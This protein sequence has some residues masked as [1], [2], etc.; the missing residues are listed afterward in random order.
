MI[1]V[2]AERHMCELFGKLAAGQTFI[3]AHVVYL[4]LTGTCWAVDLET[5]KQKAFEPTYEV[6]ILTCALTYEFREESNV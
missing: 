5:G 3:V 4:K 2:R 1:K 6:Q